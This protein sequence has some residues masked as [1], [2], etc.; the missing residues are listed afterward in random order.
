MALTEHVGSWW[1]PIPSPDQ[2]VWHLGPL[3]LRAYAFC[4]ILGIFLAIWVTDRRWQ[5]RGGSAGT[6]GDI[7]IWAV[8]FGIIGGRIYHVVTEPAGV[9]R[10]GRRSLQRA[11]DL[12]RRP[13][14]LGGRPLGALGAWIACRRR[15]IPLP[16][17]GDALAPGAGA[18]AGHRSAGATGSTRSCSAAR[19]TCPGDSRSTRR[20]GPPATPSSHLPPDVPLRVALAHRRRRDPGLGGPPVP[21]GPRPGLRALCPAYTVGR[22]LIETVRIDEA[23][24]IFGVRVNVWVSGI[25]FAGAL[26]YLVVSSRLRPGRE[27]EDEL[28]PRRTLEEDPVAGPSSA[29]VAPVTDDGAE[30]AAGPV[31]EAEETKT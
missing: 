18:G 26:T 2:G 14:H 7:A 24:T 8:P 29:D 11:A 25:C 9:L 31:D 23:N 28:E 27:T 12:E 3:P 22:G 30:V 1:G 16:P 13:R 6:V 5:A 19:P 10:L 4:I 15:G 21:D 20:T 17:F